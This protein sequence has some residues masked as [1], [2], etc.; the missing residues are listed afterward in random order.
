VHA[1]RERPCRNFE[2]ACMLR[3]HAD[4]KG[5]ADASCEDRKGAGG[6]NLRA[7]CGYMRI[8][9]E[10]PT[11]AARTGRERPTRAA[12]TRDYGS[13]KLRLHADGKGAADTCCEDE[14][15]LVCQAAKGAHAPHERGTSSFAKTAR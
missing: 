7:C 14:R 4:R 11:R 8:G 13:A 9:R 6:L 3:L 12:R 1:R 15:L 5:A 10:Q 2:S